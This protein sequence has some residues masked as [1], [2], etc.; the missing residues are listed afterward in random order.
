ML[1]KDYP[2]QQCALA[3]S[4]EV[5]GERWTLLILRDAFY[6]VRRFSDFATHLEIPRAVLSDRLRGL[7]DDGLLE[8]RRRDAGPA[9]P[10]VYELTDHGRA[11]WPALFALMRWGQG[12]DGAPQPSRRFLH[13]ACDS[14]L[15]DRGICPRCGVAPKPQDILTVV[16]DGPS[17]RSGPVHQALQPA[18]HLLDPLVI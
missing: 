8:R 12:L 1:G 7:V 9:G 4:L 6:G 18:R 11:L 17:H 3:R 16:P 15:D 5:V 10:D 13:A 2:G 14:P